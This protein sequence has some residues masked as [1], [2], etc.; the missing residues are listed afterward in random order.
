MTDSNAVG[1]GVACTPYSGLYEE[2]QPERG[3][4]FRLQVYERL[5]ILVVEVYEGVGNSVILVSKKE[6]TG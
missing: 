2:A 4:I 3:T 5:G 1:V 6:E